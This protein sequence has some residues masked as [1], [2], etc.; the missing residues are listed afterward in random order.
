[1][2]DII[3][4]KTGN[5]KGVD[6]LFVE[7]STAG[8]NRIIKFQYPGS[9]NQSVE[10]Q[11]RAK[12]SFNMTIWIPHENY[13]SVRDEVL[14][15]LDDGVKG[16]FTHPT[17]GAIENVVNG[18][19]TLTEKNSEL[20]RAAIS[21]VFEIDD[22]DGVPIEAGALATQV[23]AESEIL[24]NIVDGDLADNYHVT[25][26]FIGNFEDAVNNLGNLTKGLT[27]A[28]TSVSP[29]IDVAAEFSQT[30]KNFS[31][32]IVNLVQAPS[33]LA[34]RVS[35]IFTSLNS[36]L[37]NQADTAAVFTRL[38]NFGDT[39]PVINPTTAGRLERI[40]NR[41]YLRAA[42]RVKALSYA[43]VNFAL[44]DY[45]TTES[46]EAAQAEL[47]AQ[48][49]DCWNNQALSNA[50]LEQLDRLRVQAQKTFNEKLTNTKSVVTINVTP[51]QPL[52][53]VVYSYYGSTELV[54]TIAE[55]NDIVLNAFVE[56]ELKVLVL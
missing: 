29:A 26:S 10:Y 18:L 55:L 53:V 50:A 38:F 44:V 43:F 33:D 12:R 27:N 47:D 52:S 9:N 8:G 16:T 30:I 39:D 21:T 48:Y 56:G 35:D 3:Q 23:A 14:R 40:A 11:G 1:M 42:I 41:D 24:N 17:F 45:T 51:M 7:S 6:I 36:Y 31:D 25:L 32:N 46:L 15:V 37:D 34:G 2:G 13:Y 4:L 49:S 22:G 5:Y 54:D 19:W 20:G 28:V